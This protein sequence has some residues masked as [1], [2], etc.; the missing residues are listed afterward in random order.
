MQYLF[1]QPYWLNQDILKSS[2]HCRWQLCN[3]TH[4]WLMANM[5]VMAGN[6][7]NTNERYL[8]CQVEIQCY[9]VSCSCRSTWVNICMVLCRGATVAHTVCL[10]TRVCLHTAAD[11]G[12]MGSHGEEIKCATEVTRNSWLIWRPLWWYHE[13]VRAL[14]QKHWGRILCSHHVTRRGRYTAETRES[15]LSLVNHRF[16]IIIIAGHSLYMFR[17]AVKSCM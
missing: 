16:R 2:M 5:L 10:C 13:H 4:L 1:V 17:V 11:T 12:M 3:G 9:L 15:H 6:R 7:G 14:N 8:C